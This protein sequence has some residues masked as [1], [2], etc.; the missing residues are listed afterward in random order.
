MSELPCYTCCVKRLFAITALIFVSVA[1]LSSMEMLD[2][3]VDLGFAYQVNS[4]LGTGIDNK[5]P[6]KLMFSPGASFHLDFNGESGGAYFRPGGFLSWNLEEVY[7][8]IAR[9]CDEAEESHMKVLGLMADFPFGYEFKTR[10]IDIGIQGGP[11]LYLR[12]PLYT[13]QEG[14]GIPA[15]FWR[16]YYGAAQFLYLSLAS[17]ISFPVSENTALLTGLRY[18]Q[19]LS[20]LWTDAPFAH[21]M[22]IGLLVSLRFG[23]SGNS[24]NPAE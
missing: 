5:E 3:S 24:S 7:N 15:D 16:A 12:I 9:P 17:W 19:P 4:K 22:Q 13:A 10:K 23:P 20:N 2:W 18:Y 6:G 21:G 8:G 1:G 14:T 11:A